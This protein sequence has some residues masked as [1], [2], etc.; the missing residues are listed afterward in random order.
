MLQKPDH[1]LLRNN[2]VREIR[3]LVLDDDQFI[4]KVLEGIFR[5]KY[6]FLAVPTIAEFSQVVKN[7]DPDIVLV[8]VVLPDG[9]GID[10]CR[11]LRDQTKYEQLF[12]LM[13]TSFEDIGS[14]EAAYRAG[15]N[16]YI[17]KPFIPF[18]IASKIH[19]I[20]RTIT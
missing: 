16:D 6:Q 9:N 5:E 1:N 20:S 11:Q 4:R 7:F 12:I 10:V 15:A 18:E 17:R 19:H 3:I 13:M 2:R 8:D 14:I